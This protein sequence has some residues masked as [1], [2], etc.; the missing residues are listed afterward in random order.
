MSS[1]DISPIGTVPGASACVAPI[2]LPL[3]E[4]NELDR[5]KVIKDVGDMIT[6][7][8]D[9]RDRGQTNLENFI[10]LPSSPSTDARLS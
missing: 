2:P 7:V 3:L 8:A 5:A 1:G 4:A 10:K 9:F 6:N